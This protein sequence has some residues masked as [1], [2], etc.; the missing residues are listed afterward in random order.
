M[1]QPNQYEALTKSTV[2]PQNKFANAGLFTT[3]AGF[4][5][6]FNSKKGNASKLAPHIRLA[7]ICTD[8][9]EQAARAVPLQPGPDSF[10]NRIM[11]ATA[12][13]SS[14]PSGV[15]AGSSIAI[16]PR[17]PAQTSVR[18][19]PT[20][21]DQ[22]ASS[23]PRITPLT[24]NVADRQLFQPQARRPGAPRRPGASRQTGTPPKVLGP[25]Q[26]PPPPQSPPPPPPGAPRLTKVQP[27][28]STRPLTPPGGPR[29]RTPTLTSPKLLSDGRGGLK[30]APPNPRR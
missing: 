14:Q 16:P 27:A 12:G 2:P 29:P 4:E 9:H 7:K 20:H 13:P 15:T 18:R 5:T 22:V 25:V 6:K 30:L 10:A 17:A 28:A 26:P 8:A 3:F 11:P 24:I 1:E 21:T 23:M 19:R